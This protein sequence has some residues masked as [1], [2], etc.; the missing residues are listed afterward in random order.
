MLKFRT[1]LGSFLVSDCSIKECVISFSQIIQRDL[2]P[3]M[4]FLESCPGIESKHAV[5]AK[6]QAGVHGK[7]TLVPERQASGSQSHRASSFSRPARLNGPSLTRL[8]FFK[9]KSLS[10]N[11]LRTT[12]PFLYH[13]SPPADPPDRIRELQLLLASVFIA[14]APTTPIRYPP[15]LPCD[16]H[17]CRRYRAQGRAAPSPGGG[18]RGR[19]TWKLRCAR[20]PSQQSAALASKPLRTNAN[21]LICLGGNCRHEATSCRDGVRSR[22]IA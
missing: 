17:V 21:L 7:M 8:S 15:S 2:D 6:S 5:D 10:A 13:P 3:S 22:Q 4:I 19:C 11:S 14:A 18:W 20:D 9:P 16:H 1:R 12:G